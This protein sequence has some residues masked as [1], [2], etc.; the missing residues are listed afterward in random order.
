MAQKAKPKAEREKSG[1]AQG[2]RE[3]FLGTPPEALGMQACKKEVPSL[4]GLF[5]QC[6][7]ELGD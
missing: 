3:S 4:L 7:G 2:L 6:N 5:S 1:W